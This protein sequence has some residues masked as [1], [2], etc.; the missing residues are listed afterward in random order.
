MKQQNKY[1]QRDPWSFWE[2]PKYLGPHPE[3]F[4][5]EFDTFWK[6]DDMVRSTL[7]RWRIH[8]NRVPLGRKPHS[9]KIY[10]KTQEH[11]K[12]QN[13]YLQRDPWSFWEIPKYL[14]LASSNGEVVVWSRRWWRLDGGPPSA[15]AS[16]WCGAEAKAHVVPSAQR[17][18]PCVGVSVAARSTIISQ[19][20]AEEEC[21]APHLLLTLIPARVPQVSKLNNVTLC[22]PSMKK[23][24]VVSL[25]I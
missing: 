6:S 9:G 15:R 5:N 20:D 4:W 1:L 2:I 17:S 19:R 10:E 22:I 16:M 23:I 18:V 3:G 8:S 21:F 25:N 12:Q 11:M 13:K 7:S 24:F 14:R